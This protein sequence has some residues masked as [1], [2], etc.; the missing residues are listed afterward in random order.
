MTQDRLPVDC[1]AEHPAVRAW[2]GIAGMECWCAKVELLKNRSA[3][4]VWRLN[5]RAPGD[6]NLIA[7]RCPE[8]N[9]I[10]E[11]YIYKEVLLHVPLT[12]PRHYGLVQEQGTGFC[13]AFVEDAAGVPYSPLLPEH[14]FETATW[15]AR[16]HTS[17]LS[18]S[19]KLRLPDRGPRYY[20]DCLRMGRDRIRRVLAR[21]PLGEDHRALLEALTAACDTAETKQAWIE[22]VCGVAPRTFVHADLHAGNIHLRKS[23]TGVTVMTFDWESAG[24]GPPAID[25]ALEGLDLP[26]Y[27]SVAA[28]LWPTLDVHT[29][30]DLTAAGR[31]LRVAALIEWESQALD[32]QWPRRPMKRMAWYLTELSHAMAEIDQRTRPVSSTGGPI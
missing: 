22:K 18:V 23:P 32:F 27:C 21:A 17:A 1:V 20:S 26:A 10:T 30:Q 5:G 14:G 12:F 7:K 24:W 9:A 4:Q 31:L 16:L 8:S 13:W 19:R 2:S 11:R 6:S 28:G 29:A 15:L 3:S 25:L